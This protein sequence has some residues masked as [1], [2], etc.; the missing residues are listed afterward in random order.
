[1]KR[2]LFLALKKMG[3]IPNDAI[4]FSQIT[5]S[6]TAAKQLDEYRELITSIEN[7][8]QFFSSEKYFWSKEHALGLDNVLTQ[9]FDIE[10]TIH[11]NAKPPKNIRPLPPY[12]K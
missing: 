5:L 12:I 11:G 7:E 3:I 10:K 4:L 2:S 1:M 9:L 6:P 8:T